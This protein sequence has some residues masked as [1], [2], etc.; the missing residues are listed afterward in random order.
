MEKETRG[1]LKEE[2]SKDI[3]KNKIIDPFEYTVTGNEVKIFKNGCE[4]INPREKLRCEALE[5]FQDILKEFLAKSVARAVHQ[6]TISHHTKV[7]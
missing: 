4:I 6:L 2:T 7:I 5:G 1:A 3:K